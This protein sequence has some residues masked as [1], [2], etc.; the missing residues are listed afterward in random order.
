MFQPG[1]GDRP[2]V[3]NIAVILTDGKSNDPDE[4][5][6]QAME[7]RKQG[8]GLYIGTTCNY[9]VNYNYST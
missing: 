6:Q 3:R 1:A 4:T 9:V 8:E 2:N 7:A 5:W